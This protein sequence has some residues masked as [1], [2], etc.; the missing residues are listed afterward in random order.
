MHEGRK[1]A[2]QKVQEANTRYKE[3]LTQRK[4]VR[5]ENETVNK[6]KWKA[7]KK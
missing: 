5:R 7:D 1:N 4:R 2:R 6:R 3:S